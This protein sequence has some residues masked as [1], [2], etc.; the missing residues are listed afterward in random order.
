MTPD[1]DW[2]LSQFSYPEKLVA[3]GIKYA[4]KIVLV[5]CGPSWKPS[6]NLQKFAIERK[7]RIVLLP[8]SIISHDALE[9]MKNFHLIS[10]PLK[11][12]P[13]MEEIVDRFVPDILDS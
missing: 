11:K 3:C 5:V 12:H 13:N 4:E 8:L 2:E 9:R 6:E 10:T 1:E 7:I